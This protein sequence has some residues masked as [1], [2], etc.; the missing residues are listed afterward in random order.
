MLA[1][2]RGDAFLA[3]VNFAAEPVAVALPAGAELL[4][5]TDAERAPGGP[6]ET[7]RPSE[8]VLLRLA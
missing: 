8:G 5:S 1:W 2:S 3:A 6:V 4:L 7:L